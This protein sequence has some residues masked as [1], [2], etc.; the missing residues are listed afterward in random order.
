MSDETRIWTPNNWHAFEDGGAMAAACADRVANIIESAIADRGHAVVAFP[1]GST[2]VPAFELLAGRPLDWENVT[3]LPGDDRMVDH[4]DKLSNFAMLE[5]H[6]RSTGA[7]LVPL[8]AD[9]E[10][11]SAAAEAAN[12]RLDALPWPLDL[13]WLGAG[14]DGHT[15]SIFPGPD[16]RDALTTDA[17]ALK[18]TPDPLPP[19]APVARITLS[20]SAIRSARHRMV[21]LRGTD[22]RDVL[23][24][25]MS[26]GNRSP[27][28]IGAVLDRTDTEFYW[29]PA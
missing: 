11:D 22:K 27:Y 6:F 10:A 4:A 5:R 9:G 26:D 23:L 15:A 25:A 29:S 24:A 20:A 17:R 1:G 13:V 14:G 2:P 18:V 21:S 12:R 16:Y 28:P 19:E 3:I 7:R 8:V